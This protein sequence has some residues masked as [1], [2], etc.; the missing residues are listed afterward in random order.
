MSQAFGHQAWI[1]WGEESTYGTRVAPASFLE[2][3]SE[4]FKGEQSYISRP[5]LRSASQ[6]YKVRSKKSVSGG[7]AFPFPWEGAEQLIEHAMGSVVTTGA[8]PYTHTYALE[9]LLPTGLTFHVNRD[10]AALG[11]GSAFEY[12]GCHIASLKFSQEAENF[13]ICEVGVLGEDWRNLAVATPTFPTFDG[14]DWEHLSA[15]TIDP[16]GTPVALSVRSW[17]L[18]I[19]NTLADDRFIL[20]SRVRRGLGRSGQRKITGKVECEFENINAYAKFRDL[21]LDDIVISLVS[22]SKSLTF[23]LPNLAFQGEDPEASDAGP[24]YLSLNFEAFQSAAPNDEL[25][26]ALINTTSSV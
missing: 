4:N 5:T 24:M 17:E 7:F 2:V 12:E 15:F 6:N 18:M 22:G 11:A 13:L 25:V 20:G 16:G 10:A 8:G 9:D 19:E 23:I 14:V 26:V 1:G 3:N 21:T